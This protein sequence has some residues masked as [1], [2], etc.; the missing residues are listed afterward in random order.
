MNTFKGLIIK[1]NKKT[2]YLTLLLQLPAKTLPQSVVGTFFG[3]AA[4]LERDKNQAGGDGGVL[5]QNC[6]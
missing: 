6:V 4:C 1:K 5:T 2:A 3:D